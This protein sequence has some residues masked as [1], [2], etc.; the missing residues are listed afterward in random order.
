MSGVQ[1]PPP[2]PIINGPK[3][4]NLL[5]IRIMKS[6]LK[7]ITLF[8]YRII[9]K[10]ILKIICC[11]YKSEKILH[12]IYYLKKNYKTIDSNSKIYKSLLN[13]NIKF[14]QISEF[15]FDKINS[16]N[17]NFK[18]K[19]KKKINL[20]IN[21]LSKII[22]SDKNSLHNCIYYFEDF[23]VFSLYNINWY[24]YS[25][26]FFTK[27]KNKKLNINFNSFSQNL[28]FSD[29]L[30]IIESNVIG[31]ENKIKN[32]VISYKP[33]LVNITL[34]TYQIIDNVITSV[35]FIEFMKKEKYILIGMNNEQNINTLNPFVNYTFLIDKRENKKISNKVLSNTVSV[36]SLYGYHDFIK[37]Y[38]KQIN[39]N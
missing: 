1:I 35:D 31:F 8:F 13:K 16:S 5:Y 21:K 34:Q 29:R 32:L 6:N 14:L 28:N 23:N 39:K 4:F 12:K 7:K 33:I 37:I 22:D 19:H 18:D 2:L 30:E 15:L 36:L 20:S 17:F 24:Y 27:I 25:K 3:Y 38:S 9:I 11:F 26:Y 10:I